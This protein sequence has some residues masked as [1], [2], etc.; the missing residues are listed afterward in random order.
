MK[1][2]EHVKQT[3]Q[4]LKNMF[5]PLF[6]SFQGFASKLGTLSVIQHAQRKRSQCGRAASTITS[7]CRNLVSAYMLH[8]GTTCDP[9][10]TTSYYYTIIPSSSPSL[11]FPPSRSATAHWTNMWPQRRAI[12]DSGHVSHSCQNNCRVNEHTARRVTS[13]QALW[14]SYAAAGGV[15]MQSR[16]M[17]II[18]HS[19]VKE[20]DGGTRRTHLIGLG[21]KWSGRHRD[22]WLATAQ[23]RP[24][25]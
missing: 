24:Q 15:F 16:L 12:R 23:S 17:L 5:Q 14:I 10:A 20:A 3:I 4:E 6:F 19:V 9:N 21:A 13:R 25:P 11:C 2:F 7:F 8:C 1:I 18:S 22:E